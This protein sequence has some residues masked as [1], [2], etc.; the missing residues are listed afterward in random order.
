[1]LVYQGVSGSGTSWT[2]VTSGFYVECICDP[3]MSRHVVPK[4]RLFLSTLEQPAWGDKRATV[5]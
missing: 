3:R 5:F 1:M 2:Q 4:S